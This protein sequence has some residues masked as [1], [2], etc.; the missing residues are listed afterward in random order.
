MYILGCHQA[1]RWRRSDGTQSK[2]KAR[3]ISPLERNF[4]CLRE[5][6]RERERNKEKEGKGKEEGKKGEAKGETK[7]ETKG[8][9]KRE[10]TRMR[11]RKIEKG[12]G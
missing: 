7:R 8:E 10:R 3:R 2:R 9:T 11:K 1:D 12:R 4:I 5:R 6:E